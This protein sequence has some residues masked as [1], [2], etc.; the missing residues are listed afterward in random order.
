MVKA[1]F[2]DL[3]DTLL[4]D[5]KSVATAFEKTCELAAE[6]SGKD[7]SRLEEAV[8]SEASKL[9]ASYS[10][11]PYTQM[12]GINPFEGLWGTFDDEGSDFQQMKAIMPD[13][14]RNAWTRGLKEIGIEDPALGE[15]LAAYFPEARRQSPTLYEESLEILEQLKGRYQLLLLTNGSPSLQQTKLEITP[16]IAPYFDHIVISGAFGSGKPDP[17]I[18]QHALSQF[19]LQPED[20]LMVG[21][22]LMTDIIGAEK[23]GI[24]SV[25]I[26]REA[27]APHD[28]I[29]PTYEIKHL[30]ELLPILEAIK[31]AEGL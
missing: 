16:E 17:A 6:I 26:N 7:C 5:K 13:Y 21:D 28:T 30:Q 18:F 12:I 22:N 24:R 10:T 14:Q 2:F 3:D 25:W 31:K 15:K 29:I 11:Y 19:G 23:A 8:R 4:W 1:I 27:K 20:A 9:Y